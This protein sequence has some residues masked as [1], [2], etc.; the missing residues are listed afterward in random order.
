MI[1]STALGTT[2]AHYSGKFS[3]LFQFLI[4]LYKL[5]N[6]HSFGKMYLLKNIRNYRFY[7]KFVIKSLIFNIF[8]LVSLPDVYIF[9]AGT[10]LS[11][12]LCLVPSVLL[13]LSY[14]KYIYLIPSPIHLIYRVVALC[15]SNGSFIF[16]IF[17]QCQEFFHDTKWLQILV[18]R[19]SDVFWC[20]YVRN[21]TIISVYKL[22]S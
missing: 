9:R 20:F 6:K 2:V 11:P 15:H 10:A 16:Q 8:F 17:L 4:L 1:C 3:K 12:R 13:K 22:R 14:D 5:W 19:V 21:I 7:Y 18:R